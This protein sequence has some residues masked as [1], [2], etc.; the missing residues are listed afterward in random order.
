VRAGDEKTV[1]K[2]DHKPSRLATEAERGVLERLEA[3]CSA[4]IGAHALLDDGLLFLSARVYSPDGARHL[5][6]AHA[7]YPDDVADPAGELAQRVADELLAAGS[8]AASRHLD[9]WLGTRRF[10]LKA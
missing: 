2:L 8:P 1:A 3:G 6:S 7:L 9:R 10:Y 4:P 5:T